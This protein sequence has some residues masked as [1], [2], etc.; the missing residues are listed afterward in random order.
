ME[1]GVEVVG[2]REHIVAS[3]D[4]DDLN[5]LIARHAYIHNNLSSCVD[6]ESSDI[7]E[8]PYFSPCAP[9]TNIQVTVTG[10]SL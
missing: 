1:E 6:G 7:S 9:C 10:V 8:P 2:G 3:H 4:C 5:E